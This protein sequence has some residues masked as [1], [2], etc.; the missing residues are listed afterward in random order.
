MLD[1]HL[2]AAEQNHADALLPSGA[3]L[4]FL[5][6]VNV[7]YI[8]LYMINGPN[9][10]V[11]TTDA[12]T[13]TWFETFFY[14]FGTPDLSDKPS[15]ISEEQLQTNLPDSNE[16]L[17]TGI[18]T[19]VQ[20]GENVQPEVPCTTEIVFYLSQ[21]VADAERFPKSLSDSGHPFRARF[22]EYRVHALP[23]SSDLLK[24]IKYQALD[25]PSAEATIR[26]VVDD[27]ST[28]QYETQEEFVTPPLE[29]PKDPLERMYRRKRAASLFEEATERRR[30]AR[31]HGGESIAL[32][33]SKHSQQS[34][35]FPS[36]PLADSQLPSLPE[37]PPNGIP[38]GVR[39][40]FERHSR[41]MSASS[42]SSPLS[43]GPVNLPESS[44]E[45]VAS[46]VEDRNKETISRV[47]MAG[48]RLYGLSSRSRKL[49]S[50]RRS[51]APQIQ[52]ELG[53][54]TLTNPAEA[55]TYKLVYHQTYKSAVF[56]FRRNMRDEMLHLQ[57]GK[58]REVV[59]GLLAVFCY[60]PLGEE[61]RAELEDKPLLGGAGEER[62]IG[63]V[64][65]SASH[66]ETSKQV[67][68]PDMHHHEEAMAIDTG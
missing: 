39:G 45:S 38:N 57:T 65:S 20:Y 63:N 13:T 1:I 44:N 47:V 24:A 59:D 41:S 55:D 5:S 32:A 4:H 10:G 40:T 61:S 15:P 27:S 12:E 16:Q 28:L 52:S 11:W 56:A 3:S 43:R 49:D 60:N 58:V 26:D 7:N 23:L 36:S 30:K 37:V 22:G 53:T 48:M 21:P 42:V 9:L 18:L 19:R 14:L 68:E 64:S 33:A 62:G 34:S 29:S 25:P 67:K 50:E 46:L 51:S 6:L 35:A 54:N 17:S 66:V 8:P 2:S 31:R